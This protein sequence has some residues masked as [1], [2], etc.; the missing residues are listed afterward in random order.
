MER[1]WGS[2]KFA[3][4]YPIHHLPLLS[5]PRPTNIPTVLSPLNAPLHDPSSSS[6]CNLR[7]PPVDFRCNKLPPRWSYTHPLR[8]PRKLLRCDSIYI[9]VQD[10]AVVRTYTIIIIDT[11][12][13]P[14]PLSAL[15]T[16]SNADIKIT[17]LPPSPPTRAQPI[18]GQ[19]GRRSCGVGRGHGVS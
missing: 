1:L 19:L 6:P 12:D 8:P 5:L 17:I 2:R 13:Y 14:V 15:V 18:S 7:P 3:V 9:P 11:V 10:L 16:Q 4:R